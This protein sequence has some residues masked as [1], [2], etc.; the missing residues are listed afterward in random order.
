MAT[1]IELKEKAEQL[2]AE[3]E[4]ARQ[5]EIKT[6]TADIRQKMSVYGLT[7]QDLALPGTPGKS[8]KSMSPTKY[9]GPNGQGWGGGRGR[10]PDWILQALKEGKD[11]DVEFGV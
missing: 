11:I 7:V 9:R 3:A 2:L 8:H 4:E 1:Y 6:V 5:S 10:K